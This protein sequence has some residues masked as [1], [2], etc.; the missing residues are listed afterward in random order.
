M[1]RRRFLQKIPALGFLLFEFQNAFNR[2]FAAAIFPQNFSKKIKSIRI[3]AKNSS[4]SGELS[5]YWRYNTAF[6]DA[7]RFAA[8]MQYRTYFN[9]EK[10]KLILYLPHNKVLVTANNPFVLIDGKVYQMTL[11]TLDRHHSIYVPLREFRR[12]INKY[13]DLQL[14]F[15]EGAG[16][17]RVSEIYFDVTGISIQKKENGTVIRIRTH[18]KYAPGEMTM[19]MRYGWLHVDLFAS[20]GDVARLQKTVPAGIVRQ[21]KIFPFKDLISLAFLLRREPLSKE[22]YQDDSTGDVV[23]VLRTKEVLNND[24]ENPATADASSP[25][26]H[27]QLEKEK[28]RW[29]I[30]TIVID[31]GHGGKDPGSI[32]I[33]H[34]K[35]KDVAL[36]IALKL[37]KIIQKK[38][39]GVKVVYTRKTDKFIPL[40]TR[41]QIANEHNGKV[42]ICIHANWNRKKSANGFETYILGP[43]KGKQA[44]N[45]V[46]KE[47]SVIQFE[48]PGSQQQYKGINNIL[49]TMAQS[50]FMRQSEH[51]ASLVQEELYRKLRSLNLKNRGVKQAP[52][53]VMVGASMPSILVET[54]F[55][56]NPHDARILRTASY[57][58]KIAEG[59]FAGL[60]KFKQ[61]YENAI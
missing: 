24:Q 56:S 42:F 33:H 22:I 13:T 2:A 58:Q 41:T 28:K 36:P 53:W 49:A 55:I 40:R 38:M 35:E 7:F 11:A 48:D 52:F 45:V 8:L 10:K 57:Q 44:K 43:E 19:D 29:L 15:R 51:L 26:T 18:R 27:D 61:D 4:K 37:G 39:P 30:D 54:G 31:A 1:K 20:K 3:S 34:L 50:A 47:N 12:L 23:V 60:K 14:D 46:L 25:E 32:G 6:I 9:E 5:V 21:V 16:E 17:M 59:I